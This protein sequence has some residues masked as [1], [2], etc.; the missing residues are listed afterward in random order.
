MKIREL[1]WV[2]NFAREI[3]DLLKFKRL[4]VNPD[5]AHPISINLK[6]KQR[7]VFVIHLN[8]IF[9]IGKF[10]AIGLQN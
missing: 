9:P 5:R 7:I 1:R 4:N 8:K 10:T 2:S 3:F 6:S